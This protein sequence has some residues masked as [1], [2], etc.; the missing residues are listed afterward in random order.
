MQV[1]VGEEEEVFYGHKGILLSRMGRN[2][3]GAFYEMVE[4]AEEEG[5]DVSEVEF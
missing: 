1:E 2:T 4:N 5:V 3:C